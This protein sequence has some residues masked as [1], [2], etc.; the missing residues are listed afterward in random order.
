[1]VYRALGSVA[2]FTFRRADDILKLLTRFRDAYCK[3]CVLQV[4]TLPVPL[5]SLLVEY[6]LNTFLPAW[7]PPAGALEATKPPAPSSIDPSKVNVESAEDMGDTLVI[8]SGTVN[9]DSVA[10]AMLLNE[11]CASLQNKT[12]QKVARVMHSRRVDATA[13]ILCLRMKKA[14]IRCNGKLFTPADV[15][16]L[17]PALLSA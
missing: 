4:A 1:M 9:G 12:G 17:L 15:P 8:E 11:I 13:P 5:V 10:T 14:A 3:N 6:G 16:K 7:F 2:F